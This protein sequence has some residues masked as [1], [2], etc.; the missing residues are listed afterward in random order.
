MGTTDL[1]PRGAL[2]IG[3]CAVAAGVAPILAALGVLPIPMTPGTPSWVGLCA[4]GMFVLLGLALVNGYAGAPGPARDL[5]QAV[6][7]AGICAAL[8]AVSGWVA[9]GP[10]ERHFSTSVSGLFFSTRR[11]GGELMGRAAFGMGATLSAAIAVALLVNG[12]MRK[13]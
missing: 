6:L 11:A 13:R 3:A 9:F 8:A 4:G 1:S 5:R 2:L 7:G 12:F 10:G